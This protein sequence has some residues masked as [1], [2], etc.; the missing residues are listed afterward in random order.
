MFAIYGEVIWPGRVF[1]GLAGAAVALTGG[2]F[3]WR[4]S[5]A[6]L[7]L[8]LLAGAAALFAVEA[9]LD[10]YFIA[11]LLGTAAAASG[12][13]KLFAGR[14]GIAAGLAVPLCLLFGGVTIFLSRGVK[15]ARRNKR[16]F[17]PPR[18]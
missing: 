9:L 5:P 2:Y 13:C 10:T 1:P 6:A 8:E 17:S 12:F 7:G 14:S 18:T 16:N 4:N 3:L 15:R 11:G